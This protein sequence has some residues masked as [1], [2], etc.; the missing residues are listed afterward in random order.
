[1]EIRQASLV[2][3]KNLI[4]DECTDGNVM[5]DKDIEIV[6]QS[7]LDALIRATG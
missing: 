7:I 5:R 2:V 4:Y 3:L 6:K 1:M